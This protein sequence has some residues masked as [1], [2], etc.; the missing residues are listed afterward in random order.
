MNDN[1]KVDSQRSDYDLY[2]ALMLSNILDSE[3]ATAEPKM[4]TIVDETEDINSNDVIWYV[5]HRYIPIELFKLTKN[6]GF[7]LTNILK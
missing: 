7:P 3:Q 4:P 1:P 5:Y 2:A 6:Q